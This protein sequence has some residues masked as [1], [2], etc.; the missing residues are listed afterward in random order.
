MSRFTGPDPIGRYLPDGIRFQL[1]EDCEFFISKEEGVGESVIAEKG[2]ITD[3]ASIPVCIQPILPQCN[4]RR[5]AIIH[6]KLYQTLGLDGKY[7]RKQSDQI[8]YNALSV[9]E[10]EYTVKVALYLGVRIGG[11]LPWMNHKKYRIRK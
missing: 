3:F 2:F 4:G 9:L 7:T 6:D 5:A 10:V 1:H 8:F 11:W